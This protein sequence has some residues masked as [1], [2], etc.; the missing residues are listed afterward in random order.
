MTIAKRMSI[1][2]TIAAVFLVHCPNVMA[3]CGVASTYS[4]GFRTA[5]GERYNHM[6]ISAAHRHLPFGTRVAVRNPSTGRSVIVRINDRGPFIGGRIIDLSTGA[7]QA[8]GMGGLAHVCIS[9]VGHGERYA[10]SGHGRHVRYAAHSAG[11]RTRYAAHARVGRVRYARDKRRD[12]RYAAFTH[13]RYARD[14]GRKFAHAVRRGR[15][16]IRMARGRRIR[17]SA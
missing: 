1:A 5:S 15:S 14:E 8:L 11:H 10:S 17:S 6:E 9:V 13:V 3:E 12:A 2:F 4:S 16:S 7:K